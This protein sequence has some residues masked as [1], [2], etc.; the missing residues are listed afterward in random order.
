MANYFVS[1]A[2]EDRVWNVENLE[3]GTY[4]VT[5]PAGRVFTVD[6]YAP[7]AGR[8]HLMLGDDSWDLDVR[9]D[10]K[11]HTQVQ[12]RGQVFD[13]DVLNE[14]QKRME[15]A[16]GGKREAGPELPSPMAGKV[17]AVQTS[18]GAVVAEGQVLLIVE[19]MK[20][21]NDIKAHKA[22]TIASVNVGEGQTVEI[23]DVL[24]TISDD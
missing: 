3:N 7:D 20:M 13:F 19:A 2:E 15:T 14:R 10:E 22:G 16:S 9:S 24:I 21:E 11:H 6:A 5:S 18:V 1:G 17:V 23:G 12:W 8:L 4:R